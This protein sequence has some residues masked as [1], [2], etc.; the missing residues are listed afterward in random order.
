MPRRSRK[1]P[2]CGETGIPI[3]YGFPLPEDFT[4]AEERLLMLGGCV[5]QGDDPDVVLPERQLC[6]G[7]P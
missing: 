7:R 6:L 4:A 5:I 1:C 3:V 2:I